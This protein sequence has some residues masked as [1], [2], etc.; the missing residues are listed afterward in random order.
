MPAFLPGDLIFCHGSGLLSAA[1]REAEQAPG[2]PV[3]YANHVAGFSAPDMVTE[4][5]WTVQSTPYTIWRGANHAFQVWRCMALTDEQR[6]I[7]A[8]VATG[9]VGRPYGWWKLG[10]HLGDAVLSRLAGHEVY[11]LRRGMSDGRYP[12]CS[13]VWAYAYDTM[14]IRFGDLEPSEAQPDDMHNA[15]RA[16]PTWAM[17]S[18]NNA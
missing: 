12:I 14:G 8:Q 4:A 9:Y 18:E 17:V 6:A 16:D 13:W 3:A 11:A 7:V 5:L 2:Q 10:L 1:I 15:V